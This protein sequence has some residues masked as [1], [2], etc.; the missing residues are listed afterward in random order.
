[1]IAPQTAKAVTFLDKFDNIDNWTIY[2]GRDRAN[3]IIIDKESAVE[4]S[5][6]K[7]PP[8]GPTN[9]DPAGFGDNVVSIYLANPDTSQLANFTL[10]FWIRFDDTI[11]KA[12]RAMVTFRMQDD[13]HYY[14]AFLSDDDTWTSRIMKFSNDNRTILGETEQRGIFHPSEW[15]HVRLD[16]QGQAFRL[17]KDS[18]IILT[19]SDGNWPTGKT[20]GIGIYNG[21]SAYSFHVDDLELETCEPLCYVKMF[22]ST[23]TYWTSTTKNSTEVATVLSTTTRNVTQEIPHAVL[24]DVTSTRTAFVHIFSPVFDW[25]S[26]V[27]VC[28]VGL[29]FGV[30]GD[31][32]KYRNAFAVVAVAITAILGIYYFGAGELWFL[33]ALVAGLVI[34]CLL[35]FAWLARESRKKTIGKK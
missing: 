24:V 17:Y 31:V 27:F 15:S 7:L 6:L 35:R 4:G 5:S 26:W 11:A 14:A 13:R 2:Q 32:E 20:L 33:G 22:I 25:V 10:S 30:V 3:E 8:A 9:P 18:S 21:Y 1:M 23:S 12:G 19:A 29:V 34:G 16:V 28:I